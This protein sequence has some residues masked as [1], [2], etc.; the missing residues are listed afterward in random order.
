MYVMVVTYLRVWV[1]C[2]HHV[3]DLMVYISP[4]TL[5]LFVCAQQLI[6]F[7]GHRIF[8][9]TISPTIIF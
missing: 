4:L 7:N 5:E 2:L 8:A 1:K 3:K 6:S 9:K